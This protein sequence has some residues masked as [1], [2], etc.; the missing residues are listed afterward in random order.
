MAIRFSYNNCLIG[1]FKCI[2]IIKKCVLSNFESRIQTERKYSIYSFS[3]S[4]KYTQH[5]YSGGARDGLSTLLVPPLH[6]Y[7]THI[8]LTSTITTFS[9][10]FQIIM[11]LSDLAQ[12]DEEFQNFLREVD[13]LF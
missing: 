12:E 4:D 3:D 8:G 10:C 11:E 13:C 6:Q 5:P 7:A 9:I 2:I 1:V